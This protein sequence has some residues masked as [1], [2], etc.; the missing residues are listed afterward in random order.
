MMDLDFNERYKQ[1]DL[2]IVSNEKGIADYAYD[3]FRNVE[4]IDNFPMPE[5]DDT[6]NTITE[7]ALKLSSIISN[8]LIAGNGPDFKYV[9]LHT[10]DIMD[11]LVYY[12]ARWIWVFP[13]FED[14]AMGKNFI[15][16]I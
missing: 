14:T 3:W 15:K 11:A 2:L 7:K 16:W 8:W 9:Y 5:I 6:Y 12:S 1:S 13:V 4:V 10:W